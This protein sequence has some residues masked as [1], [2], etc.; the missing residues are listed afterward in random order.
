[1]G[2]KK[3][4]MVVDD[5]P[6]VVRFVRIGLTSAGYE[7][8]TAASGEEALHLIKSREPDI[9]VL[10]ILMVPMS[11]LEVLEKL[12]SFSQVPVIVVTALDSAGRQALKL[13]ANDSI[14]KPFRPEELVKRIEGILGGWGRGGSKE[15]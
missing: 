3:R 8:A 10:D 5:E 2:A 7:V 13:G 1:M 6:G 9:V 15:P 14:A 11:G 12:R 4:V